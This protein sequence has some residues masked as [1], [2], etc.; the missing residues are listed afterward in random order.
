MTETALSE[1]IR[2]SH[3]GLAWQT[4]NPIVSDIEL[5]HHGSIE[6]WRAQLAISKSRELAV[7]VLARVTR[8]GGP[9][10]RLPFYDLTF[11]DE[12]YGLEN[13]KFSRGALVKNF[14][15]PVYPRHIEDQMLSGSVLVS[16]TVDASG[17]VTNATTLES[18]LPV[19]FDVAALEAAN[20]LKFHP[21][22]ED[23]VAVED[24]AVQYLFE[25]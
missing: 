3:I 1:S 22:L 24:T 4:S 5:A 16:L 10:W 7:I 25:F 14:V 23:G 12:D 8:A 15:R 18:S 19:E 13:D 9:L 21:K 20:L 2:L 6:G 17:N 11:F